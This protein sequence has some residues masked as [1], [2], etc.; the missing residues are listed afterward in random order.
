MKLPQLKRSRGAHRVVF[1][2]RAT[3]IRQASGSL[4]GVQVT[5]EFLIDHRKMLTELDSQI[6]QPIEDDDELVAE[7]EEAADL[8]MAAE[9]A[10]NWCPSK[11][12]ELQPPSPSGVV[13]PSSGSLTT[14]LP[15]LTV[16]SFSGEYTQWVSFWDQFTTLVDRKIDMT[17]VEKLSY[18]KLSV[19]GDAAQIVSSLLVTD[20][21]Y[22]FAKLKALLAAIHALPAIKKESSIELRKLL[23]KLFRSFEASRQSM[24][25]ITSVL[26]AGGT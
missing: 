2:R 22:D 14:Q 25:C 23:R 21:N 26:A 13:V 24:G 15:M 8:F 9:R 19:K 18:F 4:E 6:P 16:P 17:N 12:K 7:V 20:A 1:T 10:I 5:L 3:A 11:I